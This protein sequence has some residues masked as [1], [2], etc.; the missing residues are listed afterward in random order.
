MKNGDL[1][2][3]DKESYIADM[4]G[5]EKSG[6]KQKVEFQEIICNSIQKQRSCTDEATGIELNGGDQCQYEGT[7]GACGFKGTGKV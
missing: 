1:C 3:I 4:A 7:E 2:K 5:Q 6:A